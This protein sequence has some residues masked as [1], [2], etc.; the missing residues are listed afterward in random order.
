VGY[1]LNS[2]EVGGMEHHSLDLATAVAAEGFEVSAILPTPARFDDLAHSFTA[3]SVAVYRLD[4]LGGRPVWGTAGDWL[5]MVTL[6]RRLRLDVLHQQRTGPYHGKLAC[7]AARAAGVPVVVATEHQAAFPLSG[8]T[9]LLNRAIDGLVDAVVAVSRHDSALQLK[10]TWRRPEKVITIYNGIDLA[11]FSPRCE[12]ESRET[13]HA[14][15][16]GDA[17]PVAGV[18]SRLGVQKGVR[19]F[20]DA[21][22]ALASRWPELAV[23]IVG[24]G[25][26]RASLEAHAARL[27]VAGMTSFLGFRQD[28]TPLMAAMDLVVVPSIW[29]PFGLV[30]AEAMAMGKPVVA[31]GVGGLAEVVA[32]GETGILVPPKDPE[33]LAEA[34]DRLL[35]DRQLRERMGR[36]GRLRAE[37]MFAREAM[38]ASVGALYQ[39]LMERKGVR[40]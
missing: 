32:H 38:V 12:A 25:E 15:G 33:A 16:I 23:P 7:L 19:H 22:P 6:L 14:L 40:V 34:V 3:A 31:S 24:D 8:A 35:S 4:L 20:L 17:T 29:E 1:Q 28:V 27:G 5:R 21:L 10:L 13:R 9:A 30:A 2:V 18:V 36:A 37:R 39:T 11:R 26:E